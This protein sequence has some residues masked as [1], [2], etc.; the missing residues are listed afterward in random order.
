MAFVPFA[1]LTG[2]TT[3]APSSSVTRRRP[4][5]SASSGSPAPTPPTS[6]PLGPLPPPDASLAA[7]C[8]HHLDAL[9]AQGG[10]AH[11]PPAAGA[12]PPPW[13]TPAGPSSSLPLSP[14][15]PCAAVATGGS[16][17]GPDDGAAVD[18]QPLAVAAT[19][20]RSPS[21]DLAAEHAEL[22]RRLDAVEAAATAREWD[23]LADALGS[24]GDLTGL[25]LVEE[26]GKVGAR[27]AVG[28]GLLCGGAGWGVWAL[29]GGLRVCSEAFGRL[30]M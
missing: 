12:L 6:L 29:A 21:A 25:Q 1:P 4:R 17:G 15:M 24:L 11:P 3:P 22:L 8:P 5:L 26:S 19:A 30:L 20:V 7:S 18:D 14:H 10:W 13:A 2:A 27:A 16:G 28:L 9:A 23:E